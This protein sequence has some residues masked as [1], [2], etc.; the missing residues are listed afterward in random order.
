M[1]EN[2]TYAFAVAIKASSRC[3]LSLASKR[4]G[5]EEVGKNRTDKLQM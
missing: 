5:E 1:R 3:S 4:I 2:S